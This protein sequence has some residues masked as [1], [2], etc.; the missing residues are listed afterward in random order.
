MKKT[1]KNKKSVL[2]GV[3]V[4]AVVTLL[5]LT[6]VAITAT[7]QSKALPAAPTSIL[8]VRGE[9]VCI[10]KKDLNR[11]L[12]NECVYGLQVA[13]GADVYYRLTSISRTVARDAVS[14]GDQVMITGAL[15]PP[16]SPEQ[17]KAVG[18]IDVSSLRFIK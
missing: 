3:I 5:G 17:Y 8:N 9:V 4:L 7:H 12:T 1:P 13:D 10:P 6:V 18:T 15:L 2:A 16:I 11:P 14:S